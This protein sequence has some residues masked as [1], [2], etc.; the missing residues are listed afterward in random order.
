MKRLFIR[1]F[2]R[3]VLT[4]IALT[5]LV[6]VNRS[7]RA[8]NTTYMQF[9][10]STV[11][12]RDFQ[13]TFGAGGSLDAVPSAG[14]PVTINLDPIVGGPGLLAT[15]QDLHIALA[16]GATYSG[17]VYTQ[18]LGAGFLDV[19][20]GMGTILHVDLTSATLFGT[21]L[22]VTVSA[23][24][25]TDGIHYSSTL[26]PKIDNFNRNANFSL[27]FSSLTNLP[28]GVAGGFLTSVNG[29]L[30]QMSGSGTF[31]GAPVPE[32]ISLRLAAIGGFGVI[33]MARRSK[34]GKSA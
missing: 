13:W 28:T 9:F 10:Q 34:R 5:A 17:G 24:M 20:T 18:Q 3:G 19:T 22:S 2:A 23:S 30:G 16:P 8:D 11:S 27:S 21:G 25:P 6:G 33:A 32:P 26:F 12:A 4:A 29:P 14:I 31:A 1:V 7:A 15:V